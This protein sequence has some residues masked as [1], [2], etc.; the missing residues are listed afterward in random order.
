MRTIVVY[1][2]VTGFTKQY[3]EWI[4]KALNCDI[5]D[6]KQLQTSVLDQYDTIIFGSRIHAERVDC[7]DKMKEIMQ[8]KPD[9]H[10]VVYATGAMPMAATELIEKMWIKNL[11]SGNVE[12]IPHFY[13]QSGLRYE[14][15]PLGDRLLLKGFAKFISK[16]VDKDS[17]DKGIG[18]ALDAS[19][20][21][22]SEEYIKPL[23][24]HVKGNGK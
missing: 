23:V 18:Q 11:G 7:L 16:K 10:F 2:S 20:D 19:F 13:M 6:Y 8:G 17:V 21:V 9:K 22:S 5:L 24:E 15:M 4:G 1:Q 12:K 14:E 3:A